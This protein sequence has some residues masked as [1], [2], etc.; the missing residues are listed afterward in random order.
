MILLVRS[1]RDTGPEDL[2]TH[3]AHVARMVYML[4]LHVLHDV[5]FLATVAAVEA[6][7]GQ[8]LTIGHPV[9]LRQN[10]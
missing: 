4:G 8:R 7:P 3:G 10:F 1:Q 6:G 9:H 5:A 2:W